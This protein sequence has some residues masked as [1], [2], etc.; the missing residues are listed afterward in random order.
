MSGPSS[1]KK[2]PW[3]ASHKLSTLFGE[4]VESAHLLQARVAF[5][6]SLAEEV[7]GLKPSSFNAWGEV[8]VGWVRWFGGW[9]IDQASNDQLAEVLATLSHTR[10]PSAPTTATHS[11][12]FEAPTSSTYDE[13]STQP[14]PLE[15]VRGFKELEDV[16]AAAHDGLL[17]CGALALALDHDEPT[18]ILDHLGST[19]SLEVSHVRSL[20]ATE[21]L[22][23]LKGAKHLNEVT[24]M[25]TLLC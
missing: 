23:V 15:V 20:A 9:C 2:E 8:G 22:D 10:E 3:E 5:M 19:C 13:R 12:P 4:H 7:T 6:A 14:P 17:D 11:P 18:D 16:V 24:P 25:P 21:G 1:P